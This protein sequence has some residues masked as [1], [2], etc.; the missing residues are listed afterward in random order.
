MNEALLASKT[1]KTQFSESEAAKELGLSVEQFRV[2]IRNHIAET[3][4]DLNNVSVASYHPSDL[5]LLKLLSGR[6]GN[7]TPQGSEA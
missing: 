6:H 2:L 1:G 7:P 4:E 5:L 3:D